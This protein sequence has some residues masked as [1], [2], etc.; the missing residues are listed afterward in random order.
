MSAPG[1]RRTRRDVL[2]RASLYTALAASA[3]LVAGPLY[4]ML[5]TSLKPSSDV[6]AAP[7]KWLP[8][9]VSLDAYEAVFTQLPFGRY[10]LNSFIVTGLVVLFNVVFDMAA[11]YAFAKLRFPGRDVLFFALLVTIMVPFQVNLIPLYRMMVALRDAVGWLGADTY[12]GLIAP[13]AV[14]VFGIFL[15][16][17]YLSS[18][19]D[20]VL[21]SARLDGASELTILWRIVVPLAR[22]AI[23][24]LAC[25]I[26][27]DTWNDFLW[28]LVVTSSD[29]MRTLPLGLA[30]L[31][32]KN[33]VDW[34][35]TM[36]GS[37]IVV[38]PML[39]VFAVLQRRFVQGLTAG[40]VREVAGSPIS[41]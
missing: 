21:E 17:Q 6:F 3:A 19:P 32:R 36:A 24:A 11:A 5:V 33:T 7:P 31:S 4:W 1:R 23:A 34:S 20:S 26:F 25:F 35:T 30:L 9:P 16:R 8:D 15:L 40:A 12:F 28:P 18:I 2:R 22:P 27:L 41:R 10:L 29:E 13:S 38:A 37:A 14:Q 39:L